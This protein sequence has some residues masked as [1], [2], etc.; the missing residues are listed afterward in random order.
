MVVSIIKLFTLRL[1]KR[2]FLPTNVVRCGVHVQWLTHDYE[3]IKYIAAC[4]ILKIFSLLKDKKKNTFEF[5]LFHLI[6]TLSMEE[7]VCLAPTMPKSIRLYYTKLRNR[8]KNSTTI[9]LSLS[10]KQTP[11]V[12]YINF[13]FP[14]RRDCVQRD[15]NF[16]YQKFVAQICQKLFCTRKFICIFNGISHPMPLRLNPKF[17]CYFFC[18]GKLDNFCMFQC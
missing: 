10:N 18:Y 17:L 11:A 6:L 9:D 1:F 13:F 2:F 15:G 8:N 12:W 7:C 16:C 4:I 14:S 3:S 5:H